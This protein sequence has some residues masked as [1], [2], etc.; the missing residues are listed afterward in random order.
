MNLTVE[1]A[2]R[3]LLEREQAIATGE[4][5]I[6]RFYGEWLKGRLSLNCDDRLVSCEGD[7]ERLAPAS[8]APS[9]VQK[10]FFGGSDL[11]K[12]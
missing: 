5:G 1:S 3:L 8:K 6:A 4:S 2:F 11:D 9:V 7:S 10:A 12:F